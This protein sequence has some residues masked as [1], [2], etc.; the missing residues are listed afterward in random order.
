MVIR[1]LAW[2]DFPYL[3]ENYDSLYDEVQDNPDL[4][5]PLFPQRPSL[6]EE[7]DWFAHLYRQVQEGSCVVAVAEEEGKAVGLCSVHR[8]GPHAE[9]QHVGVLGIMVAR[10]WRRRGI[11]RALLRQVLDQ[12]RGTFESV[13]LTVFVSNSHARELYRSVGFRPWGIRTKA[14]LRGGRH[15]D[16]E[17]MT[18]ELGATPTETLGR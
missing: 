14:V 6:G 15:I 12:C 16:V 13:D 11:G 1:D 4:G 3:L 7:V 8:R 2:G 9:V 10:H 18:L 17:H 5:I